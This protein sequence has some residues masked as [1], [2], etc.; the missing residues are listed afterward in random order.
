M[1]GLPKGTD[2]AKGGEMEL[3]DEQVRLL[4]YLKERRLFTSVAGLF[5]TSTIQALRKK[6]LIKSADGWVWKVGK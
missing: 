1:G 3:T 2:E 6:K 5:S 4:N